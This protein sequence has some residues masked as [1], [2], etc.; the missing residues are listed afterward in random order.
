MKQIVLLSVIWIISGVGMA[1]CPE[2][3]KQEIKEEIRNSLQSI[4]E[5]NYAPTPLGLVRIVANAKV[6]GNTTAS[7]VTFFG[8][9]IASITRLSIGRYRVNLNPV[10]ANQ[11]Y[12]IQLSLALNAGEDDY[13]IFYNNQQTNFFEINIYEQDNGTTAGVPVDS[14]FMVTVIA[15]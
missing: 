14:D 3:C 6:L 12:V 4:Y 8:R 7:N 9:G 10:L 11:N 5:E 1:T 2:M 15:N 13:S